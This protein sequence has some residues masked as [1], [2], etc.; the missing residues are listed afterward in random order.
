[1]TC[2]KDVADDGKP[3]KRAAQPAARCRVQR[4]EVEHA[5][6]KQGQHL[7]RVHSKSGTS[8][9]RVFRRMHGEG[10]RGQ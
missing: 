5:Q 3:H 10:Q 7:S 2:Q 9:E 4:E 1:M 6:P 8:R